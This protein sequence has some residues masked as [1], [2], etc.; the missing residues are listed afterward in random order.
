MNGLRLTDVVDGVCVELRE[1]PGHHDCSTT[2]SPKP[3]LSS[4]PKE[5]QN[6]AA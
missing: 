4:H 5:A 1:V 3:V 6:V 2:P